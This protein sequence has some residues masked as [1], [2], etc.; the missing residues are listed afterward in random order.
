L[1]VKL[2]LAGVRFSTVELGSSAIFSI[3][4]LE[5]WLTSP[6]GRSTKIMR[7]HF[8]SFTLGLAA[9]GVAL[10]SSAAP[11]CSSKALGGCAA[12]LMD[13]TGISSP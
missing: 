12:G 13:G 5:R 7:H 2:G 9:W 1:E 3:I 8:Y 4:S 11:E 6:E 10:V